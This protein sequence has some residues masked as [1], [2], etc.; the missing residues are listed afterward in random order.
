MKKFTKLEKAVCEYQ[1][2]N[3]DKRYIGASPA[4]FKF[5]ERTMKTLSEYMKNPKNMLLFCGNPGI[6]KTHFCAALTEWTFLHFNTRRYHKEEKILSRL[7]SCISENRGEYLE[8]L[9]YLIDDEIIILDD[10]GSGINPGKMTYRD[11]EF[12]REV[13]FSFLD[14]RYNSQ[15]PTVITSNF[16]EKEFIE[17]YSERI[18]SRLFASENTIIQLFGEEHQDKRKLGM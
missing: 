6:G 16:G 10:V 18:A 11:Y 9:K 8:E 3:F 17:V 15:L 14:Y 7:R 12:R 5:D 4:E 2:Q 1:S 13:F